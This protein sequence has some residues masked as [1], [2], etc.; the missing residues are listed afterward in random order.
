MRS[1]NPSPSRRLAVAGTIAFALVLSSCG[2]GGGGERRLTVDFAFQ[3]NYAYLWRETSVD[4]TASGLDGNQPH[5]VTVAPND[6][7]PGLS[8]APNTCRV[9]GLPTVQAFGTVIV[10]LTVPGFQGQVDKPLV[11][12]VLGPAYDY[13]GFPVPLFVGYAFSSTPYSRGDVAASTPNWSPRPGETLV[14]SLASGRLPRGLNLDPN[15]GTISGLI[16]EVPNQPFSIRVQATSQG[17]TFSATG[18]NL[19]LDV[20]PGLTIGYPPL[21]GNVGRPVFLEPELTPPFGRVRSDYTFGNFRLANP[22]ASLPPGL[23]LNSQT[24]VVSGTPAQTHSNAY[25]VLVDVST[26][27]QTATFETS[28]SLQVNP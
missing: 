27:G 17:R 15:T 26:G 20:R 23:T 4:I 18:Q 10:R 11:F 2:G 13:Y 25:F 7:A 16:A 28:V 21:F 1:V 6:F 8:F 12:S 5:C 9:T 22:S 19:V 14:Y 3:Q 24:G